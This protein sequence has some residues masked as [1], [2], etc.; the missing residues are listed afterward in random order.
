MNNDVITALREFIS[1]YGEGDHTSKEI[2]NF[3]E[4][5]G[6][7]LYQATV[8]HAP[9]AG[10]R[11]KF[12]LTNDLADTLAATVTAKEAKTKAVA[13][14]K[15]KQQAEA[16]ERKA[17]R[18]AERKEKAAAKEAARKERA[19]KKAAK[20]AKVKAATVRAAKAK[21]QKDKNLSDAAS[22]GG[23]VLQAKQLGGLGYHKVDME[24]A[25]QL[26]GEGH[27]V[28]VV[29]RNIG[30]TATPPIATDLTVKS[31]TMEFYAKQ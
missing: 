2:F 14:R 3:G 1:T 9:R 11:G 25:N 28:L 22:S 17:K 15:A 30:E 23:A 10:A 12:T 19:D 16:V 6:V 18:E 5:K 27:S 4:S 20:P 7:K 29:D 8:K 31:D 21:E 26:Y 24:T 13:E